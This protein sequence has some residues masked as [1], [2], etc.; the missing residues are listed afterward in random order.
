[1]RIVPH[2]F[3]WARS[4]VYEKGKPAVVEAI[5]ATAEPVQAVLRYRKIGEKEFASVPME[6]GWETSF[7]GMLPESALQGDVVEYFVE[8]SSP[9]GRV[10]PE[11]RY[12]RSVETVWMEPL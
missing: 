5:V 8:V 4:P 11:L 9:D 12:P 6:Q 3:L 10:L 1:V 2:T 7:R